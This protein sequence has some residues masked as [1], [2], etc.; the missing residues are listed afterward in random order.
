MH[1]E[2]TDNISIRIYVY[3]IENIESHLKLKQDIIL[4]F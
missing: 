2:K 1:G 3:K 4:K